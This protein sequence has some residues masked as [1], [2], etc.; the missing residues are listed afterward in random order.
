VQALAFFYDMGSTQASEGYNGI[1]FSAYWL[2]F[3]VPFPLNSLQATPP[4]P[5]VAPPYNANV[6]AYDPHL[7]LP[8]AVHWNFSLEPAMGANQALTASYV[9][10]GSRK[11]LA[12][13]IYFPGALGNP[14]FTS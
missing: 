8:Y 5:S 7:K 6:F 11:L 12:Q 1:G 14:D 9:G 4:I 2:F 13:F 10:L 3:S